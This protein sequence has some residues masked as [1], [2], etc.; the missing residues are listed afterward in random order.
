MQLAVKVVQNKDHVT[1]DVLSQVIACFRVH[2]DVIFVNSFP[3]QR[4]I[5]ELLIWGQLEHLNIVPLLGYC[6]N[7]KLAKYPCPV[8]PWMD[9]GT[10]WKFV[11]GAPILPNNRKLRLSYV[12]TSAEWL[13]L[14]LN[15]CVDARRC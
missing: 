9:D 15:G 6:F 10:L 7:G 2:T 8:T 12:S 3:A 13:K 4:I 11:Y 1:T 14:P 5:R